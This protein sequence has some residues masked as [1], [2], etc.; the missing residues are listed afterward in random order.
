MNSIFY[1][2]VTDTFNGEANYSWLLRYK[3]HAGTHRG[4]V[5]KVSEAS[6]FRFRKGWEQADLARYN[7]LRTAVCLFISPYTDEAEKYRGVVSL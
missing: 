2:E 5:R 4:A 7:G 1:V 6:G 3:V